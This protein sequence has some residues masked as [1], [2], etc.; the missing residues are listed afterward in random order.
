MRDLDGVDDALL[1]GDATDETE[2]IGPSPFDGASIRVSPLWMTVHGTAGWVDAW[3]SLIAT[4]PP[5][6]RR[7]D[8]VAQ[9]SIETTVE[10]RNDRD[11]RHS[12]EQQTGPLEMRVDHI[13]E[14]ASSSTA[15]MVDRT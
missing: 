14:S 3:L 5:V 7:S 13:D 6:A 15:W 12:R 4:R 11:R 10:R 1:R 2:G 9:G 8:S